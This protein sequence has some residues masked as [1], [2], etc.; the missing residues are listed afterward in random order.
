MCRWK[1]LDLDSEE[2]EIIVGGVNK[3]AE[4]LEVKAVG[5]KNEEIGLVIQECEGLETEGEA[6]ARRN[7]DWLD[8]E[9]RCEN[10]NKKQK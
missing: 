7:Q 9:E 1:L 3:E 5:K 10:S 8:E 4:E 2:M 6:H